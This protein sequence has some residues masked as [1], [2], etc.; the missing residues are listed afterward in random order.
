MEDGKARIV[1][2]VLLIFFTMT[3]ILAAD[4]YTNVWA[5]KIRGSVEQ[6]KQI[7]LKHGFSYERHVSCFS[8]LYV[9]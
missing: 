7:A 5:V 2:S 9:V 6:A 1:F 4:T 3:G 8:K